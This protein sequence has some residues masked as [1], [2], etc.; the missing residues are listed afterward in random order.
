M[1]LTEP[2]RQTLEKWEQ[3]VHDWHHGRLDDDV[4]ID[5]ARDLD[6][7]IAA[8]QLIRNKD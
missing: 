2:Q 4:F 8:E 3:L 6:M 1:Q 5:K 7:C